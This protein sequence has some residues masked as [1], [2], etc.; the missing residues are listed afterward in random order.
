[1][2][3]TILFRIPQAEFCVYEAQTVSQILKDTPATRDGNF[4]FTYEIDDLE[5]SEDEIAADSAAWK[6]WEENLRPDFIRHFGRSKTRLIEECIEINVTPAEPD[7]RA[8]HM[9]N[10]QR[11]AFNW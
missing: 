7:D 9:A 3:A 11:A 4:I 2:Q 1:M 8:E 6:H 5:W 10:Y